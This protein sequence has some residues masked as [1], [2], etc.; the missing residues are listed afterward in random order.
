M[1]RLVCVIDEKYFND[2]FNFQAFQ[3]LFVI[4]PE[5]YKIVF[6]IPS[7]RLRVGSIDVWVT[8]TM[9]CLHDYVIKMHIII[10]ALIS[11]GFYH[12]T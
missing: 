3:I 1:A 7:A 9:W 5:R 4:N 10:Y 8:C 11:M 2:Y 12:F 6:Q